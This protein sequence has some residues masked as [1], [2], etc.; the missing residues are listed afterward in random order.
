MGGW[1]KS[2]MSVP[3]VSHSGAAWGVPHKHTKTH[4]DTGADA[5]AQPHTHTKKD[6]SCSIAGDKEVGGV[7]CVEFQGV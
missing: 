4:S 1:W 3:K 7:L 6:S 5:S 2:A